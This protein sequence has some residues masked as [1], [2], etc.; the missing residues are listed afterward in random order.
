MNP[1]IYDPTFLVGSLE[2]RGYG[3]MGWWG[4]GIMWF[5]MYDIQVQGSESLINSPIKI[6]RCFHQIP[7]GWEFMALTSYGVLRG[8]L[9]DM[10]SKLKYH[11]VIKLKFL[12]WITFR[13]WFKAVW[14]G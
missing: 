4:Y 7:R 11:N 6:L 12:C 8:F 3:V 13:V 1:P 2:W 14:A 5:W 10:W 9:K